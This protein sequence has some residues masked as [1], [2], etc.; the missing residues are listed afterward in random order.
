MTLRIINLRPPKIAQA[1]V[2][3]AALLHIFTPMR[4]MTVYSQPVAG[5]VL[6]ILGFFIMMWGWSLF[7]N[8]GTAICPTAV[9]TYLVTTGIYRYTRNPMYLG[10]IIVLLG[11]AI[12]VGSIPF[13][14]ISVIYFIIINH[15]FCPYEE[16]KLVTTFGNDY[17]EYKNRVRRWL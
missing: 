16:K 3:V 7:K 1:L 17:L 6:G 2:L 13:Y 4:D 8:Q 10:V 14:L 9:N 11:I 5:A 15:V 12:Y